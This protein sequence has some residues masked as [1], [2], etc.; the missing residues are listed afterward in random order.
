MPRAEIVAFDAQEV[1]A[2]SSGVSPT[3]RPI[4]FQDYKTSAQLASLASQQYTM[5]KSYPFSTIN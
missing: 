5:P 4:C 2:F 3:R 1:T